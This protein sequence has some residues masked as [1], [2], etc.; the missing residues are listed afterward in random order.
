MV[1]ILEGQQSMTERLSGIITDIDVMRMS[2]DQKKIEP[3]S[4]V[5]KTEFDYDLIVEI[6]NGTFGFDVRL[7][8]SANVEYEVDVEDETEWRSVVVDMT[9]IKHVEWSQEGEGSTCAPDSMHLFLLGD[10]SVVAKVSQNL[11]RLIG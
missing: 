7:V 11:L 1:K 10:G 6:R 5:G 3:I 2:S 4:F 8:G 9:Q